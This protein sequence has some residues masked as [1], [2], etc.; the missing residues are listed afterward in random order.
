ME[1]FCDTLTTIFRGLIM[2]K[3]IYTP[4]FSPLTHKKG[5]YGDTSKAQSSSTSNDKLRCTHFFRFS[6]NVQLSASSGRIFWTGAKETIS[7]PSLACWFSSLPEGLPTTK[8][9]YSHPAWSFVIVPQ[10][11]STPSKHTQTQINLIVQ[12]ST[13]PTNGARREHSLHT[14]EAR[15]S[16]RRRE[17]RL[18]LTTQTNQQHRA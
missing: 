15:R 5:G 12:Q 8:I 11:H 14:T 2:K 16:G 9:L 7:H 1:R 17:M 18:S 13:R 3:V 10:P 6:S 4:A